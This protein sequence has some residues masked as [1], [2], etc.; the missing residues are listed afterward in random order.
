METI[1]KKGAKILLLASRAW[2]VDN[3]RLLDTGSAEALPTA[4]HLV[5]L[6]KYQQTDGAIAPNQFFRRL[7]YELT[8]KSRHST[9]KS[10]GILENGVFISSLVDKQ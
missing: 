4:S 10:C 2:L 9:K 1:V 5:G 6:T 7:L 8:L 3:L